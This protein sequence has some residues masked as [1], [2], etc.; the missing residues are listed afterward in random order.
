MKKLTIGAN[1]ASIGSQA[2]KKCKKLKTLTI[3]TANLTEGGIRKA[4]KG[5]S[6]SKVKV[7]KSVKKTYKKIFKK[8]VCGRNV[9]IK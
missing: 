4:L 5:S 9:T 1:V 2:F 3:Q 8:K 6:V 7:P